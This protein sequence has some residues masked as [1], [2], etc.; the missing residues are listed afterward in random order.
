MEKKSS[1]LETIDIPFR[2]RQLYEHKRKYRASLGSSFSL[3][4]YYLI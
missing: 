1:D 3:L 4:K 2:G